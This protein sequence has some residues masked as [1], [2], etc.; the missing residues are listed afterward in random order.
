[1]LDK[2]NINTSNL[3]VKDEIYLK[4]LLSEVSCL[5]TYNNITLHL[6][7]WGDR[8]NEELIKIPSV[9]HLKYDRL[10]ENIHLPI[11]VLNASQLQKI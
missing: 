7:K 3:N 1:M 9:G 8:G 4:N 5:L 11:G 2:L 10:V 6:E